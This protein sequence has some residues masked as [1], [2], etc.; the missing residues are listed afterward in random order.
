[1]IDC[2]QYYFLSSLF[3]ISGLITALFLINVL[4]MVIVE[5]RRKG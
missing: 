1:M 3:M 2:E 4:I 5:L